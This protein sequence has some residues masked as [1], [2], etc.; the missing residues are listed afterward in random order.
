M[1][2][3]SSSV[4]RR[5]MDT[6]SPAPTSSQTSRPPATV[7]RRAELERARAT[8]ASPA[9]RRSLRAPGPRRCVR[10]RHRSALPLAP[11]SIETQYSILSPRPPQHLAPSNQPTSL[12][13]RA[14]ACDGPV[15]QA[16]CGQSVVCGPGSALVLEGKLSCEFAAVGYSIDSD[17]VVL[18]RRS[19]CTGNAVG[20]KLAVNSTP[21]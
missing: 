15:A 3:R 12:H 5:S 17:G 18:D 4:P 2:R 9:R 8:P 21:T 6:R 13:S 1:P 14:T 10:V 16:G 11:L 19:T 7:T 20:G